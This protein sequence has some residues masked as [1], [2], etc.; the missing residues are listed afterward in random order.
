MIGANDGYCM[1]LGDEGEIF[2]LSI[3]PKSAAKFAALSE[4]I[5]FKSFEEPFD[6]ECQ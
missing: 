3:S 4:Q 1:D 6:A 5:D 2:A